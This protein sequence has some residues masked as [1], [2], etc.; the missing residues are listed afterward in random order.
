MKKLPRSDRTSRPTP[1]SDDSADWTERNRALATTL[2]TWRDEA[3][4]AR[5]GPHH[6]VGGIGIIGDNQIDRLVELARHQMIPT[7]A[8]FRREFPW[9][10]MDTYGSVV[11]EI[12]HASHPPHRQTELSVADTSLP[13][14]PN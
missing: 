9:Y 2:Y 7:V 8:D 14:H 13:A 4:S 11:L 12:V 1:L 5:W 10:H 3:A 6:L